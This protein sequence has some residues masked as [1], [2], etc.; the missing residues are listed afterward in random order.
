MLPSRSSCLR[1]A[2]PNTPIKELQGTLRTM[3]RPSADSPI[4]RRIATGQNH[5]LSSS[6]DRTKLTVHVGER[7]AGGRRG[8]PGRALTGAIVQ[9]RLQDETPG[10]PRA[11]RHCDGDEKMG[12]YAQLKRD[13][14]GGC[15]AELGFGTWL[16]VKSCRLCDAVA[17]L[18]LSSRDWSREPTLA[19]WW[20]WLARLVV[21]HA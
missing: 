14:N 15:A 13:V 18:T 9:R 8:A 16:F 3:S 17:H 4:R 6:T 21:E 2:W 20:A 5:R 7:N 19:T 1:L 10:A 11:M 12:R